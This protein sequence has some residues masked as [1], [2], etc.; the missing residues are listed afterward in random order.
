M[1]LMLV[2]LIYSI[3]GVITTSMIYFTPAT[4]E[5][6]SRDRGWIYY[7]IFFSAILVL[8]PAVWGL[9]FW[10]LVTTILKERK[11]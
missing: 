1:D 6:Q 9:L 11:E 3:A 4:A 7:I 2:L 10:I 8:W 5:E